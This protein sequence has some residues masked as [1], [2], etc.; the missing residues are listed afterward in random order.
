MASSAQR[1]WRAHF[2]AGPGEEATGRTID[3]LNH[4]LAKAPA[5][6]PCC[7]RSPMGL[8]SQTVILKSGRGQHRK[9]PPYAFTERGALMAAN[10]LNSP[11]AVAMSVV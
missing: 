10:I 5:S 3:P 6:K 8:K 1:R 4:K 11:R 2:G 9:H 7:S